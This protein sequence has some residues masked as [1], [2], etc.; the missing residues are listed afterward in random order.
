VDPRDDALLRLAARRHPAST[1]GSLHFAQHQLDDVVG[2]FIT[3]MRAANFPGVQ[4]IP[5]PAGR[6]QWPRRHQA[7]HVVAWPV[8][9]DAEATFDDWLATDGA[10]WRL[11]FDELGGLLDAFPVG[12]PIT[13]ARDL[14]RYANA[15][16]DILQAFGLL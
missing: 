10:W 3:L 5:P 14:T 7:R 11:R 12:S 15:L 16:D 1:S 2:A 8:I 6:D 9:V 13:I 4:P